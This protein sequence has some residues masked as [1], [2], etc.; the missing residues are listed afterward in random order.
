MPAALPSCAIVKSRSTGTDAQAS[1][2]RPVTVGKKD[3]SGPPLAQ[4]TE[5][6]LHADDLLG[7]AELF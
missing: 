4:R 2:T 3:L 5:R 7:G 1:S 6:L